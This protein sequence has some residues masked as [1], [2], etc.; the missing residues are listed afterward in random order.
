MNTIF[1]PKRPN[2][3]A[4]TRKMSV[5][6]LHRITYNLSVV[7]GLEGKMFGKRLRAARLARGMTQEKTAEAVGVAL[8]TYQGYEQDERRPSYET[9]VAL[10]D[11]L[12][13]STDHLLGRE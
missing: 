7:K 6:L 13:V 2:S 4:F 8:R 5:S 3:F 11:L 1:R 10:A 9:L 12:D